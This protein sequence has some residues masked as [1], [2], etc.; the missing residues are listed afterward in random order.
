[1]S[2]KANPYIL[3]L[4]HHQNWQNFN[5]SNLSKKGLS[6]NVLIEQFIRSTLYEKDIYIVDCQVI[7]NPLG[8]YNVFFT[9]FTFFKYRVHKLK[10][11]SKLHFKGKFNL[12]KEQL[13]KI[14]KS[15]YKFFFYKRYTKKL[16]KRKKKIQKYKNRLI[17]YTLATLA[18]ITLNVL[19]GKPALLVKRC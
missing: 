6:K 13:K 8:S 4:A 18:P 15:K 2:F 10:P 16:L 7:A 17:V 19:K 14:K 3:R 12:F 9:Y 11:I 1:M 5:L